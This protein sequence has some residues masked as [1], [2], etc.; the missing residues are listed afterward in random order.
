MTGLRGNPSIAPQMTAPE[1][2]AKTTAGA[3]PVRRFA[4][5]RIS[6]AIDEAVRRADASGMVE[7]VHRTAVNVRWGDELVTVAHASVGGLPNGIMVDP[8]I[9]LDQI[10]LAPGMP[11]RGDGVTLR[12]PGASMVVHLAGATAWSPALPPTR[13]SKAARIARSEMALQLAANQAP[14]VGLGPLLVGLVHDGASAG[15][16]GR[17]AARSL[18]DIVRSL[19]DGDARR[20]V[21]AAV[22]LIGLGPGATPSGD[23]L[24]VGLAA[25]LIATNQALA[26]PFAEGVAREAPGRTTS[27]AECYLFH[28]GRL[29]FAERVHDAAAAVL[30]DPERALTRAVTIALA[31]GASSGADLLVGLLVGIQASAA[32]GL[33][34]RLHRCAT[35]RGVAA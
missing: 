24:L 4:A 12:I 10:G 14:P 23:D 21:S 16:L 26:R 11:V 18:A 6:R 32:P 27:V 15:S 2:L 31:W 35:E 7:G 25:G 34:D 19:D 33:A 3:F 22:P 5:L 8:P 9:A 29:E 28:A 30:V 13:V 1:P 17:A 20:A